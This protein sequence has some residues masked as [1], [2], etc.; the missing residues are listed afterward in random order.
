SWKFATGISVSGVRLNA[1]V[2]GGWAPSAPARLLAQTLRDARRQPRDDPAIHGEHHVVA[3]GKRPRP[4]EAGREALL[5]LLEDI[6]IL[7]RD[8]FP[9]GII[10]G[11]A[12]REI[13]ELRIGLREGAADGQHRAVDRDRPDSEPPD[14]VLGAGELRRRMDESEEG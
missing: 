4:R 2:S 5:L 6:D 10:G 14:A 7:A 8:R 13:G 12:R 11:G 9:A 3:P 1:R